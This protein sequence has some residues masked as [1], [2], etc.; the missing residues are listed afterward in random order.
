MTASPPARFTT[1]SYLLCAALGALQAMT[2]IAMTPLTAAAASIAPPV[3]ALLTVLTLL[4][5]NLSARLLRSP[6]A[7]LLTAALTSLIVVPFSSLGFLIA[8]PLLLQGAAIAL[9]LWLTKSS[10]T[11]TYLLAGGVA[12]VVGFLVALPVFSQDDLVPGI[13][14]AT[15]AARV[16]AGI[17]SAVVAGLLA[18]ALRA[19]GISP[20]FRAGRSSGMTPEP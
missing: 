11:W 5:I 14:A 9:V 13:L 10:A 2:I 7:A 6:I 16:V 19:A 8:I 12:G 3:Y 1:R 20:Q 17:G 15:F 18:K 4:F